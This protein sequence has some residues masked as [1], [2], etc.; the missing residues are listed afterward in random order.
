MSNGLP[1]GWTTAT[2]PLVA[3]VL[4]SKRVPLN[5]DERAQR[6]AGKS[7]SSLVPYFGA[8]GQVGWIDVPLF[9]ENLVLLG[10]DGV[11][12]LEFNKPKAYRVSGKSWVNNHAHVLRA[13]EQVMDWRLLMARLNS[14]NYTG[15]V[16]GTTRLKLTQAAMNKLPMLVPP[17]A[18][19]Q[20]IADKLDTVL[21][22]VEAV[23]ARLARVGPL[24]KRFRQAVLAAAMS[25]RLTEGWRR[26]NEV[27][28]PWL[29]RRLV[30]LG[31]LGRGKSKHRPRNDA[32]LYGGKHPFVQTGDVANAKGWITSHTQTYSELGLA[33]SKLWPAGTLCITIAANI[34]DTAL[35]AYPA[36]FP[37]SVVGFVADERL[38][39]SS[40][41][42]WSIDVRKDDLERLAPATA[43][44]NIN[45][46]VLEQVEVSLPG[47]KE[48]T[49]I[50]RRVDLLFAY[51]DRL[52]ARLQAAQT[53]T[54]RLT[55][56]L[57][58]KAFRGE[59]VPQDPDDEPAAELLKRLR[60]APAA[61][62]TRRRGARAA[63]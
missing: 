3:D 58:A 30:D 16:T 21:A 1:A 9:D 18:E 27:D 12:F 13:R 8:T 22:R 60:D 59:L 24:L 10:E 39:Q 41:I 37:D 62:S 23:N 48:Q 32:R 35:L 17:L 25:G 47:L 31:E 20:R 43:Q 2:I 38:C 46:G 55:P 14:I 56:A 33:Q 61:A 52:E 19:Q 40:F 29:L 57:L 44:K 51:A 45:L 26:A 42:K 6:V 5:A 50:V 15:Y 4:D 36:C 28:A 11:A 7:Q 54:G 34:A 49:E 53:A 63:V